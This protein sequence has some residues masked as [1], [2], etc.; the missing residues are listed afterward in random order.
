VF[1]QDGLGPMPFPFKPYGLTRSAQE[2][3]ATLRLKL[4]LGKTP[5]VFLGPGIGYP[6]R[7]LS[8]LLLVLFLGLPLLSLGPF[9]S[10]DCSL[11]LCDA[12]A[13]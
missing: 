6:P 4:V 11:A 2:V 3:L 9:V 10:I 7:G 5:P 1:A 12:L 13:R 8:R